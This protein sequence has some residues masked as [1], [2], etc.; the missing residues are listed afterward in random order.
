VWGSDFTS[1]AAI[2]QGG[3]PAETAATL[4]VKFWILV[5]VV[6]DWWSHATPFLEQPSPRK[7]K[8]LLND[9]KLIFMVV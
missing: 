6:R 4:S 2:L 8:I 5:V 7:F 9:L 3:G 1:K